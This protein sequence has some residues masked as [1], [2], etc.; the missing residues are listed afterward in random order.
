[1]SRSRKS[2]RLVSALAA[3][4]A[5]LVCSAA[6]GDFWLDLNVGSKHSEK[7]YVWQ[8]RRNSFN[9]SNLGL[10]AT[11]QL[12]TWCDV[13]AGWF[14]NSYDRTSIY[15]LVNPKWELLH[16][17]RWSLA[18]GVAAGLVTGY[19]HTPEQTGAVAPWGM[20]TLSLGFNDRWRVNLGYIPSRLF[21]SNSIDVA[22]LQFTIKL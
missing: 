13:K 9:E 16:H 7:N 15:A 1:M 3:A 21:V 10:G 14:D 4:F 8:G 6:K 12:K 17:S 2:L 20:V 19:Q 22:T 11:Y 5:P 18:P